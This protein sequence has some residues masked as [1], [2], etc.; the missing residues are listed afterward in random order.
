[1]KALGISGSPRRGGNTDNAVEITLGLI[2]EQLPEAETEFVRV[3]D[4]RIEHCRG[5]RHC[6]EA[7]E[8]A[9]EGD[10]LD[11]LVEKMQWADLII[12]GAPVYWYGPPGVMKDLIDRTHSFYPDNMRLEGKKVALISV[13]STSGFPSHERI[14]SWLQ[15]YGAQIV[16]KVRLRAREKDDLG[17]RRTQM[18][19]LE[20]FA[21]RMMQNI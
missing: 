5:C 9:I 14:M 8:C 13:A 20:T 4:H 12:L 16:A 10:D 11:L 17:R 7:V 1:M 6:M 18:R 19:K 21:N 15:Y 2:H 3:A